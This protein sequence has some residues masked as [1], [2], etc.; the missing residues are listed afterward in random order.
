[1]YVVVNGNR[2]SNQF[3]YIIN[4]SIYEKLNDDCNHLNYS[5]LILRIG[6]S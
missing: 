1:M 3:H 4:T 2:S 6:K 5:S